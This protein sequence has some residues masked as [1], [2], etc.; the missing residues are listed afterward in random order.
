MTPQDF[1]PDCQRAYSTSCTGQKPSSPKSG[2]VAGLTLAAG[3]GG[4]SGPFAASPGPAGM[5]PMGLAVAGFAEGAT[6]VTREGPG[7]LMAGGG[8]AVDGFDDGPVTG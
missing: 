2:L 4:V 3:F 1:L 8:A 5:G 6:S 7:L